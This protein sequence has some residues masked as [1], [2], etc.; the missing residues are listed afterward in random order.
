MLK[1][2]DFTSNYLSWCLHECKDLSKDAYSMKKK[3]NSRKSQ[4]SQHKHSTQ[5]TQHDVVS[6]VFQP[7]WLNAISFTMERQSN[8]DMVVSTREKLSIPQADFEWCLHFGS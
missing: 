5:N 3:R 6:T 7:T 4:H 8:S 1:L 2:L